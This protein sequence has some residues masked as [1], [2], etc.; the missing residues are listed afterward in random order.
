MKWPLILAFGFCLSWSATAQDAEETAEPDPVDEAVKAAREL[1]HKGDY[2]GAIKAGDEGWDEHDDRRFLVISARSQLAQGAYEEAMD[3]VRSGWIFEDTQQGQMLYYDIKRAQGDFTGA[4]DHLNRVFLRRRYS[5]PMDLLEIGRAALLSGGEPK[6]VLQRFYR[7]VQKKEPNNATVFQYIGDLALEKYDFQLAAENYDKG[8]QLDP[9]NTDLRFALAKTF[10]SSDRKYAME[11]LEKNLEF[12]PKHVDSLLLVAEHHLLAEFEDKSQAVEMMERAEKV[13]PTDSRPNSMRAVMALLEAKEDEAETF[14]QLAKKDRPNDPRIDFHIG[15]WM[16]SLMRFQEA[17]PYLRSALETDSEFL[18]AKI[19]LGRNL[20][21]TGDE[22]EAWVIL[23]GV[24][25]RDQYN[26]A[27]YNLLALHD[28]IDDYKIINGKNFIVRMES[29]EAELFG[30]RVVALLEKGER[31]LHAKYGFT[32]SKPILVEFYPNQE[33]FAVRTLGFMGGDGFLGACFGLVVTMNSPN[34]G[35]TGKTNWESTLWHEY[36]H[37]V[38]LGATKNRMPRWLTEGLST[39]EERQLDPTCGHQLNLDFRRMILEDEE[40]IPLSQLNYG[41]LRPKSG[42]HMEFAY[43]QSS[44]F[45][46]YFF[47]NFGEEKLRAIIAD[48]RKGVKFSVACKTHA[49]PLD[50]MEKAFFAF[51]KET[52]QAY[53]GAFEWEVPEENLAALSL[54]ELTAWVDEHPKNF[55]GLRA[56]AAALMK[57]DRY[58]AAETILTEMIEKFPQHGES[59]TP[60]QLLAEL[61]QRTNDSEKYIETLRQWVQQGP[62]WLDEMLI[63][64]EHDVKNGDWESVEALAARIMAINPY[65]TEA[66][67]GLA[68]GLHAQGKDAQ[69]V[70]VYERLLGLK[71][72]NPAQV[73]FAVASILKEEEPDRAKRHTLDALAEAPRYREAL[74]LL[75]DL[76]SQDEGA[77]EAP[78]E[79]PAPVEDRS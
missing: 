44:A 34:N 41:F 23:E 76:R 5:K 52:A 72:R 17:V 53:G 9:N 69:S 60:Y 6:D 1:Y 73:H 57:A 63:L 27:V 15:E 33:D 54:D 20:L 19:S 59:G 78:V 28:E 21:R 79:E 62:D 8:L 56:K 48:L 67:K 61:Y 29:S 24:S 50:K 31:E 75:R 58:E 68:E 70:T 3:T 51:I 36:C 46:D 22:D 10:F 26:V 47:A 4:N 18:P 11:L 39:Y 40:L 12:N 37:A 55:Y 66:Q 13:C 30:D 7:N 35:A 38:T 49:E 25:D 2:D 65:I 74:S 14:R 32:P 71:P 64:L 45:I 16:A 77:N 42:Q 43:Y